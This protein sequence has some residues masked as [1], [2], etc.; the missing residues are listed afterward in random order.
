MIVKNDHRLL[1]GND[2]EGLQKW[3]TAHQ[4]FTI[5][6]NGI[7]I[8]ALYFCG[9]VAKLSWLEWKDAKLSEWNMQVSFTRH[10]PCVFFACV[11]LSLL[12]LWA[13]S[14]AC[15]TEPNGL[16]SLLLTN[17]TYSAICKVVLDRVRSHLNLSNGDVASWAHAGEMLA[18]GAWSTQ[19]IN[20]SCS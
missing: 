1:E 7:I 13:S 4:C 6:L 10:D 9:E 17:S 11:S 20:S 16:S 5:L 3:S 19:V 12:P 15:C 8:N 18:F 14:L 2:V